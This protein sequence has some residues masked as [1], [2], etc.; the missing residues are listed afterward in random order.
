MQ[1]SSEKLRKQSQDH[2]SLN[3]NDKKRK[4]LIQEIFGTC[5]ETQQRK[6]LTIKKLLHFINKL[7]S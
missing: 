5:S 1:I 4:K 7:L 2:D 3:R 6:Q